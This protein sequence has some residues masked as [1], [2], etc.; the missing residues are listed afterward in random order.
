MFEF[1]RTFFPAR[2]H[3][4]RV[5]WRRVAMRSLLEHLP[6]P[7][8]VQMGDGNSA[9]SSQL[10]MVVDLKLTVYSLSKGESTALLRVSASEIAERLTHPET[11][12]GTG[13]MSCI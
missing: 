9:C 10:D 5:V 6:Y 1:R 2:L 11:I 7:S 3:G 8:C 4:K 13:S 12:F